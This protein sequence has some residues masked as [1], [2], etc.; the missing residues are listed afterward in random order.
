M[1]NQLM[2]QTSRQ[3]NGSMHSHCDHDGVSITPADYDGMLMPRLPS[4]RIENL[5]RAWHTEVAAEG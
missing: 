2:M 1:L 5:P 3:T 4:G